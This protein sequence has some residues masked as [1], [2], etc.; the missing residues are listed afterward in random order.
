MYK[1]NCSRVTFKPV[2]PISAQN[3]Q[4]PA[5]IQLIYCQSDVYWSIEKAS[6]NRKCYVW[7][8]LVNRVYHVLP[9]LKT[10]WGQVSTN[11][12]GRGDEE[13]SSQKALQVQRGAHTDLAF[14]FIRLRVIHLCLSPWPKTNHV[15]CVPLPRMVDHQI[16]F[17]IHIHDLIPYLD[18]LIPLP[19]LFFSKL[20][21]AHS[22]FNVHP[23]S[24]YSHDHCVYSF[25]N[26]SYSHF[27]S[28]SV[29]CWPHYILIVH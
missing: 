13:G 19:L 14:T 27:Q 18:K 23:C 16:F 1:N 5:E 15:V 3:A 8:H 10:F 22:L 17:D 24:V 7:T 25:P 6:G 21:L 29:Q 2:H 11:E 9:G 12:M 26:S 4:H 20:P 28:L